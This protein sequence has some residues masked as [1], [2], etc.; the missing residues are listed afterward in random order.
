M[1]PIDVN[2][3]EAI[4]TLKE[5]GYSLSFSKRN[6]NYEREYAILDGDRAVGRLVVSSA[7]SSVTWFERR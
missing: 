6:F 7:T 2:A 4:A 5:L 1:K 3:R